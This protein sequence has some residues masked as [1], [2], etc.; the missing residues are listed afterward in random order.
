[1][2]GGEGGVL[3]QPSGAPCRNNLESPGGAY[4]QAP[5][6]A[7]L[8]YLYD[9]LPPSPSPTKNSVGSPGDGI[10]CVSATLTWQMYHTGF[11]WHP[12]SVTQDN[13][14]L[15]IASPHHIAHKHHKKNTQTLCQECAPAQGMPCAQEHN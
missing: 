13:R 2:G 15:I 4:L 1:M 3:D 5:L 7:V 11:L 6:G 12:E 8:C 9:Q 10:A 14:K